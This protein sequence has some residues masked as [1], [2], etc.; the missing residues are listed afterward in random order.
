M[1]QAI[2]DTWQGTIVGYG[3]I[4]AVLPFRLVECCPQSGLEFY[5][6]DFPHRVSNRLAR[7]QLY[8]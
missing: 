8:L 5:P 6:P 7:P 2:R 4:D 1:T 3:F